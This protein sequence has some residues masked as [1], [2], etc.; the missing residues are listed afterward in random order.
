MKHLLLSLFL[1]SITP[2]YAQ[3][4]SRDT[5]HENLMILAPFIGTWKAEVG[6]NA[7]DVSNYAWIL[8][9]KAIRIM[10]S[11]NDGDYGGEALLHWNTDKQAITFR[12]VTTASFYTEGTITPTANGFDAHEIV[13]GNMGGITKTRAGY[14]LKDGEINVWSQFLKDGEWTEKSQATY[15]KA[16]DAEVRFK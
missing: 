3:E 11:I 9:G 13:H 16:A 1:L 15:I 12:Y 5:A 7:F 4:S 8:G 14:T 10:H 2:G 6:E